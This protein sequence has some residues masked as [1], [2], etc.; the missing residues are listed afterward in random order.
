[1]LRGDADAELLLEGG[2]VAAGEGDLHPHEERRVHERLHQRVDERR[3]A[4]LEDPVAGVKLRPPLI[5]I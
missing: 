4:S 2:V 5:C 3:L 1:M